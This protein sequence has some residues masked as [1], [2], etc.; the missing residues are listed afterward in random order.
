[1]T[2]VFVPPGDGE[3]RLQTIARTAHMSGLWVLEQ[4]QIR[5]GY[6]GEALLDA[7]GAYRYALTRRWGAGRCCVWVMC[8][9]ST[10]DA[11]QDD[12]TIRR[13]VGYATRWGYGSILVLNL[14][15]YRAT[16]P[17][18][19]RRATD[20]VGPDNDRVIET[21]LT[22]DGI[23]RVMFAW[24]A[25]AAPAGRAARVSKLVRSVWGAPMCLDLTVAAHPAHPLR[26]RG[27]LIPFEYPAVAE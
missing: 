16:D 7:C 5:P 14:F 1:M 10:A 26:M 24:G 13:C 2:D 8:N 9:P 18:V 3:S 6:T 23:G 15:A 27:D 20:P 22:G 11:G 25:V 4:S 12:A 21:A 17:R 19:M